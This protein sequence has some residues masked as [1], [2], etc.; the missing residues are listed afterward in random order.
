MQICKCSISSSGP[1]ELC[2]CQ[3]RY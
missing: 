2:C 3:W 1:C